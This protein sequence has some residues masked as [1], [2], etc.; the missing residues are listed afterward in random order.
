MPLLP[1]ESPPAFDHAGVIEWRSLPGA[2]AEASGEA[3]G[4]WQV[5]G[6]DGSRGLLGQGGTEDGRLKEENAQRSMSNAQRPERSM[7][8]GER[9]ARSESAPYLK[10]PPQR[11]ISET[12]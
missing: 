9:V 3:N 1:R 12:D 6:G 11:L 7:L 8:R 4:G 2:G 10:M 5:A